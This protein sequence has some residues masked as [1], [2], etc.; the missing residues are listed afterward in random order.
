[1]STQAGTVQFIENGKFLVKDQNSNINELKVGDTIFENDTV[2]GVDSNSSSAKIEILLDGNDVIV[3]SEGQKQLIDNS[4]IETAFGTEELYFTREDI[5]NILDAHNDISDVWSNLEGSGF[6]DFIDIT[7]EETAAGEEDEAIEEGSIGTFANR[8]GQIVDVISDLRKKSWIKTQTYKE[9]EKGDEYDS[10]NSKPL[11]N[12][13]VDRPIT[14]P[15]ENV[16][17]PTVTPPTVTPPTSIHPANLSINDVTM[18]EQEGYMVFTIALDGPASGN[19]SV[20]F[21]TSNITAED[22]KDYIH[23]T[24][25]VTILS[26]SSLGEIKIPI[27]DDYYYEKSEQFKVTLTNPIGNVNIVKS[28]GI[29]TI[30]DNPLANNSPLDPNKPDSAYGTYGEEDTVFVIVSGDKTVNEGDIAKYIVQIVDKNGKEVIVTKDTKVTVVYKNITT[31]YDDTEYKDGEYI[32]EDIVIKAGTSKSQIF[33]VKTLDDYLADNGENFSIEIA[34]VESTGEFEN[35]KIGDKNGNQKDVTTTILDNTT[36]NP[37]EDSNVE[38]NMEKVILKIVAADENGNPIKDTNGDYLTQNEVP[39]GDNAYYVVLAFEPNTNKFND[40]TKLDVQSGTVEVKTFDKDA[41]GTTTQTK[42]DGTQDYV[43]KTQKVELGKVI[44]VETLDDWKADNG[45]QYEIK[46]TDKSYTHPTT[47]AVYENVVTDKAPVTTTIKDNTTTNPNNPSTTEKDHENVI[48]KI[49]AVD[50]DGNPIIKDGKYTFENEVAEGSNAKYMVLAFKPDTIEF[51]VT[52]KLD[53]QS[54][55]VTIKTTD[56]TAK[57]TG[58]KDNAELDYKSEIAKEVEVGKVFEIETLDDYLADDGEKYTVSINDKSYEHPTTGAVYENVVT[59]KDPVTTTIKDNTTPGTEVDSEDVKIVLVAVTSATTTIADITN[60][61]G[62]LKITNTNEIPEG[63]KLYY[64]AVAVDKDGKPLATQGGDVTIKYGT[65]SNTSDKDATADVDYDTTKVTTK[66]GVVFEVATKDDYYAEGDEN[67]TVKITDLKNSPY[68]TSTIDTTKDTVTSTIKDNTAKIN[69]ADT[70]NGEDTAGN[71]YGVEDTVYAII[72][73]ETTVNEG[74]SAEYIVK[75]VDKNGNPVTVTKD[76]EVIVKY[77]NKTTQDGDTEYKDNDTIKITIKAW[78]N[79]SDRFTVKTKDDYWA[80]GD[81]QYNVKITNVQNT[82]EFENVKFDSY[83]DTI[84]NNLSNDVTTTIKDNPS[85]V[86]QPDTGTGNDDP[87]NGSYGK[88]DT[89]YVKIINNAETVEGGDLVHNIQ[90]IDKDEKPVVISDGEVI[91]VTL[92]YTTNHD[93]K[94]SDFV[95]GSNQ[96]NETT[97]TITVTIDK[98]TPKDENGIYKLPIIN[99]TINDFKDE[100]DEVYTLTITNVA[101]KDGK[102]ENIAIGNPNGGEKSVTGTIKDGVTL[103]DPK[104]TIVYED[105]LNNSA[106]TENSLSNSLGITNPNNDAYTVS[107]DKDIT[108]CTEQSN[109]QTINYSYNE[110]GTV[111][112]AKRT[113]GK[114]VFT[115]ELK[116]DASGKD[117]YDF[118]LLETMDH[119]KPTND[120]R[121]DLPFKFNVTSNGTTSG[122]K[123]FN[124][125]VVDSVPNAEDKTVNTNEDTAITI[126]L[127]NDAFKDNGTIKINGSD[128]LKSAEIDIYEPFD[129]NKEF[130][131]GKLLNN[132]DGTVTFTPSPDYSNYDFTKSP[133]F[134]YTV[135]DFDGDEA[136]ATVTINVKPVADAPTI[137]VNDVTSYED[138]SK[139]DDKDT[140]NKA[141][142]ENKIPLGLLVPTLSEDQ[143]DKNGIGTKGDHPERNG[144]ITLTFS[145]VTSGQNINKTKLLYKN[146]NELKY[147]NG[148]VIDFTSKKIIK[149]VIVDENGDIDTSYHHTNLVKDMNS[150]DTVYLTQSEYE[151]LKIQHEEDNDGDIKINIAVTSYEVDNDGKPLTGD[152]ATSSTTTANMVVKINP[153]T[154]KFTLDWENTISTDTSDNTYIKTESGEKIVVFKN[155]DEYNPTINSDTS[156]DLKALLT[157]TSGTAISPDTTLDLDGSEKRSYTIKLEAVTG[158]LPDYIYVTLGDKTNI[159]VNKD[160]N[161]EYKIDFSSNSNKQVDP[162]FKIKFPDYWSGSVKG[163]ITLTSQDKGVDNTDIIGKKETASVKFEATVNPVAN[164]VTVA[165]KQSFGNEDAGR[166]VITG[167]VNNDSAKNGI[168]LNIKVTSDD[169]DGSEKY[170]ID[171]KEIPNGSAL[172]VYDSSTSKYKL[173]EVNINGSIKIDGINTLNSGKITVNE[174]G[175]KYSVKIEDYNNDY[176]PKYIPVHNSNDDVTLKVDAWSVDGT[177]IGTPVANLDINVKVKG[178]ADIPTH[179]TLLTESINDTDGTKHTYNKII[180]EDTPSVYLKDLFTSSNPNFTSSDIIGGDSSEKLFVTIK[181][182]PSGFNIDGAKKVGDEWIV[183]ADKFNDVKLTIPENYSGEIKLDLKLQTVENDGDK[184]VFVDIPLSILVTPETNDGKVNNSAIQDEDAQNTVLDFSYSNG[185]DE[186]ENLVALQLDTSTIRDGVTI[187]IDGTSYTKTTAGEN[188]ID[189]PTGATVTSSLSGDMEHKD[190]DY[191]FNIR[192]K[193]TDTTNDGSKFV[194]NTDWINDTYTVTVNPITDET[195]S[196]IEIKNQTDGVTISIENGINKVTVTKHGSSFEVPFTLTDIQDKDGSEKVTSITISGVP[197]GVT[198]VGAT[199]TGDKLENVNGIAKIINSGEWTLTLPADTTLDKVEKLVSTIEFKVDGEK[200]NFNNITTTGDITISVTHQ[201]RSATSLTNE[202]KFTLV[203]DSTYNGTGGTIKNDTDKPMDLVISAKTVQLIEDTSFKLSDLIDITDGA[204]AGDSSKFAIIISNLPEGYS[205]IDGNI[206]TKVIDGKTYYAILGEGN[207]DDVKTLLEQIKVQPKADENTLVSGKE[208]VDFDIEILTYISENEGN[209]TN[210]HNSYLINGKQPNGFDAELAPV[211]DNTNI[212]ITANDVSESATPTEQEIK[213]SLSNL[214]DLGRVEIVDGKVY[215]TFTETILDKTE[216]EQGTLT[217]NGEKVTFGTPYAVDISTLDTTQEIVFKYTPP[218]NRYGELKIDTKITTKELVG[219]ATDQNGNQYSTLPIES[220]ASRILTIIP[221]VSGIIVSPDIK[222]IGDEDGF[223]TLDSS[224]VKMI[225]DTEKIT[226]VS[227]DFVPTGY[228]VYYDGTKQIG[229]LDG[230]VNGEYTYKYILNGTDLSKIQIKKI[231]V[232]DFSGVI[233]DLQLTLTVQEKDGSNKEQKI[234]NLD[235]IF[236]PK[237]DKLLNLTTTKTF[238]V[239]YTWIDINI[240]ANV[241]DTDGSETLQLELKAKSGSPALDD[242]AIFK[243]VKY[244]VETTANAEFKEGVWTIKD[245]PFDQINNLQMMYHDYNGDIDV[246]VKTVDSLIVDGNTITDTLSDTDASKGSFNLKIDKS[247]NITTGAEDNKIVTDGT[248]TIDAG[249]GY[250]T[251]VLEPNSTIDFSKLKNIEEIDLSKGN[252]ELKNIKLE[253]ILKVTDDKNTLKITG[254]NL[255]KVSFSN[256]TN[257]IWSSVA[258][259][260]EDSGFDIYSN[261]G[262]PSVKVK[263]Q[264]DIVD[265]II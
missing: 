162:E 229:E 163:T 231:G 215:V 113:D 238:G 160:S 185:G 78:E 205:L 98:N 23:S 42:E 7:E 264:T 170:N 111:L 81:E 149:F 56:D 218:A 5:E 87:I 199:Y 106:T 165:I 16:T 127:S 40:N 142:G 251:I 150:S 141:E 145:A 139:Y 201:D 18:Y 4:L 71:T 213:I 180:V 17:P 250:D 131:I 99:K 256:E 48:L 151:G 24:G 82:G 194:K 37:N 219:S 41:T 104:N 234:E 261:S 210:N 202:E 119:I 46:I 209:P 30:L 179:S 187:T 230:K 88:E 124:V 126:R 196:K 107:F 138:A 220:T 96:Y 21:A 115:V 204:T 164:D 182:V 255:D 114:T 156:I 157:N 110:S 95:N 86:E 136:T 224:K 207:V 12:N 11:G 1:M 167:I 153:V 137:T 172:Y 72:T 55:K 33:E 39:E 245:I 260:G 197:E 27:K 158:T 217:Y 166:D 68:E 116:K 6:D 178:I 262:D 94:D 52:D 85:K 257:K 8:D 198:I 140:G 112:T 49:V 212:T 200:V 169:K 62:T 26:G 123:T 175:G 240:N 189:I 243:Y 29:G 9:V 144:E 208:K 191:Q 154:D 20:D 35:I 135:I 54:G 76:T 92:T 221:V 43:S 130:P 193:L 3:L 249:A 128:V 122:N 44:S 50:K 15:G 121:F 146:D 171:L 2:Y 263:V 214:A 233:K 132:G 252:F 173:I 38:S 100:G 223:A 79:S 58:T 186:N 129:I 73:G 101:Q 66:V 118:K 147:A 235:V 248:Q 192:Y 253:D 254:D 19:I 69:Q 203:V 63:G 45:E 47:G 152:L 181:N 227:L 232:E 102:F 237:A 177:S 120:E 168:P 14:T 133:Q 53:I 176:L 70:N 65:T 108:T 184:S 28:E 93:I 143:Y 190:T 222:F 59:D 60:P 265:Q 13:P 10:L 241:K 77:T 211:S 155:I 89:V 31:S 80:E 51:K 103:E 75:L 67:F 64:I 244:G 83:P 236:N 206:Q 25:V 239:E 34:G 90:L 247:T 125:T 134:S 228:E 32:K 216:S 242:T 22:G 174:S 183:E 159:K 84:P 117:V 161:N 57:T 258:G 195:G 246:I 259:T 225:D 61:D 188:W 148:E 91:T 97:K 226:K 109:G 36:T 105:G 74:D